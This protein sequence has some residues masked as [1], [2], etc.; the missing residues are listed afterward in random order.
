MDLALPFICFVPPLTEVGG[1]HPDEEGLNGGRGWLGI[2]PSF[3]LP[4]ATPIQQQ[5]VNPDWLIPFSLAEGE[6]HQ[7]MALKDKA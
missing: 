1:P 6:V 3:D 2:Q 5:E 7:P 4:L